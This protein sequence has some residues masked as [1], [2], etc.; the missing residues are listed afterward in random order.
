[1]EHFL[2]GTGMKLTLEEFNELQ[3]WMKVRDYCQ[4]AKSNFLSATNLANGHNYDI[5]KY[6]GVL[7]FFSSLETKAVNKIDKM[8]EVQE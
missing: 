2:G 5:D 6:I 4:E 3:R 8:I 7:Q 1:M